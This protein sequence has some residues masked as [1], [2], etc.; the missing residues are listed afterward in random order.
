M[1]QHLPYDTSLLSRVLADLHT[2]P[3]HQFIL[4]STDSMEEG[5]NGIPTDTNHWRRSWFIRQYKSL[6]GSRL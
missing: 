3:P 1:S 6:N 4:M 5:L 2:E